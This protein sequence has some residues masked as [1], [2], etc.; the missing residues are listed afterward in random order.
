MRC[1]TV[2]S[3]GST[4]LCQP[5]R[6]E[7]STVPPVICTCAE[8]K[9]ICAL[10][11]V[12]DEDLVQKSS[13]KKK[14][15]E[16]EKK[17]KMEDVWVLQPSSDTVTSDAF[18]DGPLL[19]KTSLSAVVEKRKKEKFLSAEH[20]SK[21]WLAI[22]RAVEEFPLLCSCCF[23]LH[24]YPPLHNSGTSSPQL[25]V[26]DSET[27]KKKKSVSV[28]KQL[29]SFG[30]CG[31]KLWIYKK[32]KRK[33]E[34]L[35]IVK[36]GLHC[37]VFH[38]PSGDR[39]WTTVATESWIPP[40]LYFFSVMRLYYFC[41][42]FQFSSPGFYSVA[43]TP[44]PPIPDPHLTFF[45]RILILTESWW[46]TR[47]WQQ[48]RGQSVTSQLRNEKKK[49]LASRCS[50]NKAEL[51]NEARLSYFSPVLFP[52]RRLGKSEPLKTPPVLKQIHLLYKQILICIW[53]H[54]KPIASK[55]HVECRVKAGHVAQCIVSCFTNYH[56]WVPCVCVFCILAVTAATVTRKRCTFRWI[57][58]LLETQAKL[59]ALTG[60]SI[61]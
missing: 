2:Q 42:V 52:S 14:R 25:D 8:N 40:V 12:A 35:I 57:N 59:N 28:Q 5:A 32:G 18:D 3:H 45:L 26:A 61:R 29:S 60:S 9:R 11:G 55:E 47:S 10:C 21:V 41:L 46:W 4:F 36:C 33:S 7:S 54:R 56:Y 51:K 19:L 23:Q 49:T 37:S 44:L 6:A 20:W 31:W 38:S 30:S 1:R 22:V 53:M 39:Q 34:I 17:K 27:G 24:L 16:K 50:T 43:G 58:L 13:Q 15:K 48:L